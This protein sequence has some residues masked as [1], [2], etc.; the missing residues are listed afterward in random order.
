MIMQTTVIIQPVQR[1]TEVQIIETVLEYASSS[2]MPANAT[3]ATASFFMTGS[4]VPYGTGIAPFRTNN[5][6]SGTVAS[7]TPSASANNTG[8]FS[9]RRFS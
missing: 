1:V 8:E 9:F 7:G 5:I 6:L 2:T 4:G 3:A